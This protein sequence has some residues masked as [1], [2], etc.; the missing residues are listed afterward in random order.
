MIVFTGTDSED[1]EA[2][3]I[4]HYTQINVQ[5]IAVKK[6]RLRHAESASSFHSAAIT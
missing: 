4:Q 2:R 3:L 1:R 6:Y 5:M